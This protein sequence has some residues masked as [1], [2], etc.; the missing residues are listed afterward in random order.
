[1]STDGIEP[2]VAIEDLRAAVLKSEA[3]APAQA[4]VETKKL[5]K[6]KSLEERKQEEVQKLKAPELPEQVKRINGIVASIHGRRELRAFLIADKNRRGVEVENELRQAAKD[7]SARLEAVEAKAR[8]DMAA[9]A[10]AFDVLTTERAGEFAARDLQISKVDITL[11][12]LRKQLDVELG[13]LDPE[14]RGHESGRA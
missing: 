9:I 1:M 3:K 5:E 4:E 8:E 6:P 11:E 10:G 7:R 12:Q 2:A 13:K 14:R